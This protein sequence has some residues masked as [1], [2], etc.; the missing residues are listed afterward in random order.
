MAPEHWNVDQGQRRQVRTRR[1]VT[2]VVAYGT[3]SIDHALLRLDALNTAGTPAIVVGIVRNSNADCWWLCV[4]RSGSAVH[5]VSAHRRRRDADAQVAQVQKAVEQ[6]ALR[7]DVIF[8]HLLE[9]LAAQSDVDRQ[10]TLPTLPQT[11]VDS[12]ARPQITD[13]FRSMVKAEP[14]ARAGM[15]KALKGTAHAAS[16]VDGDR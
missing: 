3:L 7:D 12:E 11:G 10:H 4:A 13:R 6:G 9:D 14:G 8:A 2:V 16:S 5:W 15:A 1:H